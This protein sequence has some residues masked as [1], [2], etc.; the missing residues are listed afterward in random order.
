LSLRKSEH[1]L[2]QSTQ[3]GPHYPCPSLNTD[4]VFQSQELVGHAV[5]ADKTRGK[6]PWPESAS[7]LY[8][9]RDRHMSAKLVPTFTD[10]GCR[11]VSA[12]DP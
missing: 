1:G 11:V 5:R 6:S 4:S 3:R 10:R 8:Q 2:E 7:E 9:P 12:T